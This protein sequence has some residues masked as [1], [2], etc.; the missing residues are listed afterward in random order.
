VHVLIS[1]GETRCNTSNNPWFKNV[2][3]HAM[4]D[5]PLVWFQEWEGGR[6]IQTALGHTREQYMDPSFRA[7]LAGA[8][9]W[10][11]RRE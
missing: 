3:T 11:A 10:S 6:V 8:L 4:G 2:E 7:H 5:H 1:V 9:E